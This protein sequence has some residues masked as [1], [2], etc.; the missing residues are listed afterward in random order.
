MPLGVFV[1]RLEDPARWESLRIVFANRAT[2][3][4]LGSAVPAATGPVHAA[5]SSARAY[6]PPVRCVERERRGRRG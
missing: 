1:M 2:E 5:T 6:A 4:L 3:R